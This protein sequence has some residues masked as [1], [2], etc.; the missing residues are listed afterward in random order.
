LA[1]EKGP[2]LVG[3][4][5]YPLH[6]PARRGWMRFLWPKA[7][8]TIGSSLHSD[9]RLPNGSG[10]RGEVALIERSPAASSYNI[11][12]IKANEIFKIEKQTSL[13]N[14]EVEG[15][16]KITGA[17]LLKDGDTYEIAGERLTWCQ[18]KKRTARR[19]VAKKRA[20]TKAT[21]YQS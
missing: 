2:K 8:I 6:I 17:R 18:P 14:Q 13:I 5:T 9:I 11:R 21:T 7:T 15:K 1:P 4:R 10:K 16:S 19:P 12:P 3:I 20:L